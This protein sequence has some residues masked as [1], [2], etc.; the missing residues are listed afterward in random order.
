MRTLK[1]SMSTVINDNNDDNIND[2]INDDEIIDSLYNLND[3]AKEAIKNGPVNVGVS[4]DVDTRFVDDIPM[5][6][7]AYEDLIEERISYRTFFGL[8]YLLGAK[9]TIDISP[10][11]DTIQN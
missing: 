3:K 1:R 2:N 9:V 4:L 8:M 6:K 11:E 7:T 10:N 5:I